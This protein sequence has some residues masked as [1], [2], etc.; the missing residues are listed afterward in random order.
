MGPATS[1]ICILGGSTPSVSARAE[2]I[3]F[4]GADKHLIESSLAKAGF[5]PAMCYYTLM[6]PGTID[7]LNS[8]HN[9]ELIITL[10]DEAMSLCTGKY[11]IDKWNLSPLKSVDRLLC[12]KILPTFSMSRL[13]RQYEYRMFFFKTMVKA[14]EHRY[15]GPWRRK[16]SVVTLVTEPDQLLVDKHLQGHDTLSVDIETSLSTINT[17]GFATSPQSAVAFRI[18]PGRYSDKI[19]YQFWKSVAGYLENPRIKKIL[20]NNIYEGMYFARYGIHMRGVWHDTMWAQKL[21]FPEFKQGLDVVGRLFTNEIYW[22]EDGKDWGNINNWREHLLYNCKDT[23]NTMEAA[24]SQRKEL[25]TRD[26]LEYF[27]NYMMKLAEPI[28]EMCCT[29]LIVDEAGLD[30]ARVSVMAE[31][32][33]LEAGLSEKINPR[34]PKQKKELL[35]SKGYKIPKVRGSNGKFSESTNE[36]SLKKLRLK[37]SADPDI[38]IFLKMAKLEKFRSSYLDFSYHEDKRVRYSIR[39]SGTETLR[40]SSG[41]DSWGLG[42]NA[43]TIP[44]KAKKFFLPPEG[45]EFIQVDLKQAESRYVA[46]AARDMNLIEM[47]ENPEKD[48]HSY[49]AAAIFGCTEQQI[50]DEKDA[51]DPS[52]R[53]LGKRSGHGANYDMQAPTF[54]ESCLKDDVIL[55]KGESQHILDT[56]HNLFPGIRRLHGEIRSKLWQKGY[57]ENPL[58]FRRYFYGRLNAATYREAYCFEPQSTIPAIVNHLMLHLIKC[59]DQGLFDF[60]LHLQCHD[61]ITLSAAPEHK[62]KI[63]Q[64]CLST[65]AWHPIINLP[66]GQLIIPVD[67][68]TGPNLAA[69]TT[70]SE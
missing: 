10:G 4:A 27:D 41:T 63:I 34:S 13:N 68:E 42:F 1:K 45:T 28:I 53:Q 70:Y 43:Q 61:S 62:A 7:E 14:A 60:G 21:L 8:L 17:M 12:P 16:S 20:Q 23:M 24:Y 33:D 55:T 39:G 19:E 66:A 36:L 49:V 47:L 52:K 22:K 26:L 25:E 29:G 35:K 54:M 65:M 50:V 58:G 46:Y 32:K 30:A 11:G 57:L 40:F 37:Y 69:M 38:E 48:V 64:M 5:N 44:K 9:L 2:G 15:P 51:G 18:E 31:L 3:P 67:A 56:Y 59:R 6:H